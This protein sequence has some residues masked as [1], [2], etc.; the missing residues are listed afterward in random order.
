MMFLMVFPLAITWMILYKVLYFLRLVPTTSMFVHS[1][2][3]DRL[4]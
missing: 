2:Q 1:K 4:G 3:L